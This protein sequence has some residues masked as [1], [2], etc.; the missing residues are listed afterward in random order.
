MKTVLE[1]IMDEI[2][3]RTEGVEGNNAKKNHVGDN[4]KRPGSN[5]LLPMQDAAPASEA[6]TERFIAEFP[7]ELFA[8]ED[9]LLA[10]YGAIKAAICAGDDADLGGLAEIVWE[11]GTTTE[12]RFDDGF[13]KA[14]GVLTIAVQYSTAHGDPFTPAN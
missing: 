8:D 10:H 4:P 6:G 7:I 2:V 5:V 13:S 11:T 3:A 14:D 12:S 9:Q 1:I